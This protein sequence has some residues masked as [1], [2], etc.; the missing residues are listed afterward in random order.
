[1]SRTK[2]AW[3]Y[4]LTGLGFTCLAVWIAMASHARKS[5]HPAPTP[6]PHAATA[7]AGGSDAA[8]R[9][10]LAKALPDGASVVSVRPSPIAALREVDVDGHIVYVTTDGRYMLQG[11]LVDLATQTDL[12]ERSEAALRDATLA[13]S[14][15]GAQ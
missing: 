13:N 11:T 3:H 7:H 8:V 14:S 12:T 4:L 9:A 15:A 1:M 6:A 2:A 5:T 10:V